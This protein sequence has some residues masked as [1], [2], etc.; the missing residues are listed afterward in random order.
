MPTFEISLYNQDVL[1]RVNDGEHHKHLS[2]DWADTHY[3]E[4][5]AADEAEARTKIR[6][7]YPEHQ[8][9]VITDITAA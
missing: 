7:K 1:D 4:V 5:E 2:D 9:F 6:A 3:I 8:G